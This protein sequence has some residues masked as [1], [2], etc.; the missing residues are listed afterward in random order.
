MCS[1]EQLTE[2]CENIASNPAVEI[3]IFKEAIICG[4]RGELTFYDIRRP[5]DA[6]RWL[7]AIDGPIEDTQPTSDMA[8][9]LMIEPSTEPEN[10]QNRTDVNS[11]SSDV[12][13]ERNYSRQSI[14]LATHPDQKDPTEKTLEYEDKTAKAMKYQGNLNF[15]PTQVQLAEQKKLEEE[16]KAK[17]IKE[18][19]ARLTD[20]SHK[21]CLPGYKV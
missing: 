17:E 7:Q 3:T 14:T 4:K 6:F 8:P 1:I 9:E 10:V 15:K 2:G 21:N 12:P 19:A 16:R 20:A 18:D 11:T 13:K 5:H